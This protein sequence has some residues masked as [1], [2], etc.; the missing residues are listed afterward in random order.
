MVT[1]SLTERCQHRFA[2]HVLKRGSGIN[3]P[4]V[5]E[6]PAVQRARRR[7]V[8]KGDRHGATRKSDP[9]NP[10]KSRPAPRQLFFD[11][12]PPRLIYDCVPAFTKL[13]NQCRFTAA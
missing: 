6:H 12:P 7:S 3:Q 8:S 5:E 4:S 13:G 10:G 2:C 1:V 11:D 9:V